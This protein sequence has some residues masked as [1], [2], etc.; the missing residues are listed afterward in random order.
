MRWSKVAQRAWPLVWMV[1]VASF[2]AVVLADEFIEIT[3]IKDLSTADLIN[4]LD[5]VPCNHW[6]DLDFPKASGEDMLRELIKRGGPSVAQ[7]LQ[8][9]LRKNAADFSFL[10]IRDS[11]SVDAQLK[12]AREWLRFRDDYIIIKPL[13]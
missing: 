13:E 4:Q 8:A 7:A 12:F 2:A 5:S 10:N 11:S 9:K 1:A 3:A 6:A